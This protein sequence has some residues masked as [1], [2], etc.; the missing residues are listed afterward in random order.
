MWQVPAGLVV[1]DA[2]TES[3]TDVLRA[4]LAQTPAGVASVTLTPE[5]ARALAAPVPSGPVS[6]RERLWSV[7]A[8]TELSVA[9]AAEAL[10]RSV[11]WLHRRTGPAARRPESEVRP[12]PCLHREGRLAFTAGAL[13]AFLQSV[14][15]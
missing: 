4:W 6:W 11:A 2:V 12:V 1:S 10:G 13:R 8:E 7:A 5:A 9:E 15:D 3:L 14:E